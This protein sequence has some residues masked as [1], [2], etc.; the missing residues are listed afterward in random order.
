M[1]NL[2][3]ATVWILLVIPA[4]QS[5]VDN[6][7]VNLYDNDYLYKTYTT[8]NGD[9]MLFVWNEQADYAMTVL[10]DYKIKYSLWED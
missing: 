10:D 7:L 6:V 3:N 2:D 1:H 9:T 5:G 8:N 4:N